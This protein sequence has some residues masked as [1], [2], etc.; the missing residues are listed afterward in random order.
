MLFTRSIQQLVPRQ[1]GFVTEVLV[2]NFSA[3][4]QVFD[5]RQCFEQMVAQCKMASAATAAQAAAVAGHLASRGHGPNVAINAVAAA[6]AAAAQNGG[7]G[8][9]DLRRLCILR[10]SFVKGWG[11]VSDELMN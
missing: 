8:V 7:V 1:V 2:S 5:L 3:L 11:P 10:M 4:L 6:A 9:D